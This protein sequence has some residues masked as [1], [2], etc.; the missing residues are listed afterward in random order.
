MNKNKQSTAAPQGPMLSQ[1]A[2]EQLAR[3]YFE[4][5]TTPAQEQLLHEALASGSY[6][7][8]AIDEALW[9]MGLLRMGSQHTPQAKHARR[10]PM[11]ASAAAIAAIIVSAGVA[12]VL[13]HNAGQCHAWVNGQ[14][15]E[16]DEA[17][18]QLIA[19]DLHNMGHASQSLDDG[20]A[21]Q[22]ASLG[23]ALETD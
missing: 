1:Q 17:V 10:W 12:L 7:G 5:D 20:V 14:L 15:V 21:M 6:S 22:L 16:G 18:S 19:N 8:P 9:T 13:Q 2:V 23:Q 4:G 11:L 3:A